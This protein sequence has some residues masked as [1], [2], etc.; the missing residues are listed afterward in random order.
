MEFVRIGREISNGKWRAYR[1][2]NQN[3]CKHLWSANIIF[4]Y[5]VT[6]KHTKLVGCHWIVNKRKILNRIRGES[7]EFLEL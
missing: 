6:G 7:M 3:E 4:G 5:P 1:K 2:I